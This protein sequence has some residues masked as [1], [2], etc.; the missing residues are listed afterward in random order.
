M[1]IEWTD[2]ALEQLGNI[3]EWV[4]NN[5]GKGVARKSYE[6]IKK[7]V[8]KLAVFPE[9]GCYDGMK[10]S[11]FYS[12]RHLTIAPNVVYYLIDEKREIVVILAVVHSS[13]SPQTVNEILDRSL[14]LYADKG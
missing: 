9:S 14:A 7:H 4:A 8:Q 13:Q 2:M 10:F 6:K 5:F 1:E 12:L 3:I 11:L